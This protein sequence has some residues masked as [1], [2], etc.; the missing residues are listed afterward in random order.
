MIDGKVLAACIASRTA[1]ERVR[2]HVDPDE[3]SPQGGAWWKLIVSWYSAD[4]TATAVDA[5]LLRQK[6]QRDL[7]AKSQET[8]L[9]WFD[10][11][12][13]APSPENAVLALLEA[14]RFVA[15]QKLLGALANLADSSEK[16]AA[17]DAY[18]ELLK[19]T[20]LGAGKIER[21]TA[22]DWLAG[23]TRERLVRIAPAG[24]QDSTGGMGAGDVGYIFGRPEMGKTLLCISILR[25]LAMDGRK[26]VY[27][28]N[29]E[30]VKKTI[31]RAISSL[32]GWTA[33][34]VEADRAR[35]HALAMSRGLGNVVFVH[36]EPGNMN[37]VEDE[38]AAYD[39]DVVF[40]DQIRNMSGKADSMT[41][42]LED[43]AITFRNLAARYRFAGLGV[44]QAGDSGDG[45]LFLDMGDVD[46]SN[47][48]LPGACDLMVGIGADKM[49]FDTNRRG[50][51][52]PKNKLG[53]TKEGFIVNFDPFRN[54]VT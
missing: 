24:L 46:N 49:T 2:N 16:M 20:S 10:S 53:Y 14:K 33:A 11:L 40:L 36:M 6:G 34:Q 22:A 9:G 15:E 27:M 45:K 23:H 41:K 44:T 51:S 48:G 19:A 5:Q 18:R 26:V 32:L 47:T 25:R 35:A 13:P 52:L 39:P 28:T 38:A 3:F 50:I 21:V 54:K 37:Q 43:N 31:G 29:E 4:S 1:Y 12:P 30:A 7:P 17:L 8:L 42:R